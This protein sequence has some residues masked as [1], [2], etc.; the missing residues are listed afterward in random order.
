MEGD[1]INDFLDEAE[2][3]P[4]GEHDDQ[5]DV[6]S[7]GTTILTN[8]ASLDRGVGVAVIKKKTTNGDDD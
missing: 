5:V 3:F 4:E 6:C 8:T 7:Q 1:W 2:V